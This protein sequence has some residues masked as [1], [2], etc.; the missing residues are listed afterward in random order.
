MKYR[1][2]WLQFWKSFKSLQIMTITYQVILYC[3]INKQVTR[4]VIRYEC[5]P[6][7]EDIVNSVYDNDQENTFK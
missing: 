7:N 6:F 3:D 2:Y 5:D 4:I 1:G